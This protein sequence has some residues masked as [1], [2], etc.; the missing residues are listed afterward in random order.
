MSTADDGKTWR[1]I[2]DSGRISYVTGFHFYPNGAVHIGSWGHGLWFLQ[3]TTRLLQD[4]DSLLG[5]MFRRSEE[6]ETA[7]VLARGKPEEPPAPRGVADPS[8]AKL[9]VWTAY[10]ASGVAGVGPDNVLQVAGRGFPAGKDVTL[11][12]RE[13][14]T[15][16]QTA[17]IDKD[18]TFSTSVRLPE[19]LPYGK[20]TIEAIGPE[21][22]VL[23]VAEI[24]EVLRGR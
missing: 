16:K 2:K 24:R 17:K 20:Y 11:V 3:K 5:A 15:Y 4:R 13:R 23:S 21:G 12:V 19:D 8:V 18:G 6:V 22:K 14:E 9:F 10:P 1:T 7:G